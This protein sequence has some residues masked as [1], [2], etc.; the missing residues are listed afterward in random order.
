MVLLNFHV[1]DALPLLEHLLSGIAITAGAIAVQRSMRQRHNHDAEQALIDSERL[2]RAIIDALPDLI[3]RMKRDGTYVDIRPA[4]TFSTVPGIEVGANVRNILPDLMAQQRIEM[5]E[6]AIQTRE[7]Q[8]YEMQLLID[9]KQ[10]WQ[11]CCIVDL[12]D[13]EVIVIVRDITDRKRSESEREAMKAQIQQQLNR[14]LLLEHITHEVR[15][16]LDRQRIFQVT[17]DQVGRLFR[18]NRCLLH[19][20]VDGTA[21]DPPSIPFVAEYLDGDYESLLQRTIP[22][23]DNDHAQCMI[24]HDRAIASDDV[25]QDASLASIQEICQSIHLKSMLVCR[26]SY[27]NAPNGAIVLQQCDRY[28]SWTEDEMTLLEAV[29]SQVGIALYHA[30]L[31]EQAVKQQHEM[32]SKNHALQ[33]ASQAAESASRSKN[34]FLA[35]MNHELRTPLNIILGFAQ[36]LQSAPDLPDEYRDDAKLILESGEQLLGLINNVLDLAKIE[37]GMIPLDEHPFELNRFIDSIELMFAQ[38]IRQKGLQFTANRL[39]AS[40][41]RIVADEGKIRQILIHV[42]SNAIKFTE[43]GSIHLNI[44]LS[45]HE[46]MTSEASLFHDLSHTHTPLYT[47]ARVRFDVK[48]TGCG[49]APEILDNIFNAFAGRESGQKKFSEGTGIGLTI[50]NKVAQLIGG[51]FS[52]TSTVKQG[53]CF[54]LDVPVMLEH[55]AATSTERVRSSASKAPSSPII[56][57]LKQPTTASARLLPQDLQTLPEE[58]IERLYDASVRCDDSIAQKLVHDVAHQESAV[59][60]K[61]GHLV[62]L[63]QFEEIVHLIEQSRQL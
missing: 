36:V 4:K 49:V 41:D 23:I 2:N 8:T 11:E 12:S 32:A 19:L 62:D 28:R 20:Y 7:P 25:Y 21:S 46:A 1:N 50:S 5:A 15:S 43:N 27:L 13:D 60:S 33:Q 24:T 55:N 52:V 47:Q 45:N 35:T 54:S 56:E 18:V 39:T 9:G 26:T 61:I 51:E 22:L 6:R 59:V 30:Q 3:I 29:A 40:P 53:A 16:S 63:F 38:K 42:L 37:A 34:M 48:D 58:W 57:D 17:V 31:L 44:S 14:V 10:Q